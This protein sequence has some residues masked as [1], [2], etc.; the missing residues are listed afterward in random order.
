MKAKGNRQSTNDKTPAPTVFEVFGKA[1]ALA[2]RKHWRG[3]FASMSESL[4]GAAA[5]AIIALGNS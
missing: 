5:A 2:L 4:G 3:N 1:D